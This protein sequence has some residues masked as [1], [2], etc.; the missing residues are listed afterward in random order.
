[1]W[2]GRGNGKRTVPAIKTART[3]EKVMFGEHP[4]KITG[5][6]KYREWAHWKFVRLKQVGEGGACGF[7]FATKKCQWQ[8]N[9]RIVSEALKK[10][11][12]AWG[13]TQVPSSIRRLWRPGMPCFIVQRF[14]CGEIAI[15]ALLEQRLLVRQVYFSG[16]FTSLAFCFWK[17]AGCSVRLISQCYHTSQPKSSP[18]PTLTDSK[19]S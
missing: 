4:Q 8:T 11:A 1:M 6:K 5:Q 10:L 3:C 2:G 9:P 18:V 15:S 7:F 14:S 16:C 19:R 13:N 17:M 12:R